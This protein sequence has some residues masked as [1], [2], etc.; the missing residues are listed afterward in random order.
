M[1]TICLSIE[2]ARYP[3]PTLEVATVRDHEAARAVAQE[4]LEASPY[5]LAVKVRQDNELLFWFRRLQ[6]IVCESQPIHADR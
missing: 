5:H 4:R 1:R 3:A 6:P 2:D